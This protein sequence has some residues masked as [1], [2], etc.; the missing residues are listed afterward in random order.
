VQQ[1][2]SGVQD[3]KHRHPAQVVGGQGTP[4]STGKG[5]YDAQVIQLP[6]HTNQHCMG[7]RGNGC[8][9]ISTTDAC[10]HTYDILCS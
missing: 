4:H 9:A 10:M 8:V 7:E 3:T 2:E 5:L 1:E 6:R